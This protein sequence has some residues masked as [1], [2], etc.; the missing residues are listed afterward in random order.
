MVGGMSTELDVE[1][2]LGETLTINVECRDP[3]GDVMNLAGMTAT[4]IQWGISASKGLP[5]LATLAIS[6]GVTITSAAAGAVTVKFVAADQTA[7]DL[8]RYY[9][10][11]RVSHSTWG[12]SIQVEGKAKIKQSLFA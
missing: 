12:V 10:E 7:L 3:N 5:R 6:S 2:N 4:D 11:L 8:G 1:F 9:H